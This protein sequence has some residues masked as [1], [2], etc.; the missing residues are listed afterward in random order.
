MFPPHPY[1]LVPGD[2]VYTV[3][4]SVDIIS[5]FQL[6]WSAVDVCKYSKDHWYQQQHILPRLIVDVTDGKM[7][8]PGYLTQCSSALGSRLQ[9]A[10]AKEAKHGYAPSK[11]LQSIHMFVV[12]CRVPEFLCR[13]PLWVPTVHGSAR[14]VSA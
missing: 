4:R 2:P 14:R 7:Q 6:P 1:L 10:G 13:R 5:T 3:K 11:H 9:Q 12:C 8:P